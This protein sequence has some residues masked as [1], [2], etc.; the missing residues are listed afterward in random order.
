[1][2]HDNYVMKLKYINHVSINESGYLF[3]ICGIVNL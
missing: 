1:M 3:L 2:V